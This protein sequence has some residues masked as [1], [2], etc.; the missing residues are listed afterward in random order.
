METVGLPTPHSWGYRVLT[1]ARGRALTPRGAM[2]RTWP[3]KDK[4]KDKDKDK[5][6]HGLRWSRRQ[7]TR[8]VV[9]S[10]DDA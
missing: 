7:G 2:L 10:C 6:F 4:D 9:C 3:Y 5:G 8:A 1:S